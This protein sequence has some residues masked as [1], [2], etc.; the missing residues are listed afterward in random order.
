MEQKYQSDREED[1]EIVADKKITIC[2]VG[3][4]MISDSP[5]Y[6]SI[7]VGTRY[8]LLRNRL[9]EWCREQFKGADCVI[10]NMETVVHV[11][12]NRSLAQSQM[13][14]PESVVGDL[15]EMGFDILNIANNH[16][17]QHGTKGFEK[18]V[19]A[20]RSQGIVPIGLKG[21]EPYIFEIG[22]TKLALLS[23]CIHLE[24]YQPDH[25]LYEDDI[26]RILE[27]VKCLRT[28]DKGI[29]I[30]VSVHWGDEFA[31][32][33][34]NAQ[35]A[36]AHKLVDLG[37]DVILGHHAHIY[38]GVEMYKGALI[39]YCQG[40]FVSDMVPEACRQTGI[41]KI[42][43]DSDSIAY[44]VV[45]CYI[46]D[47]YLPVVCDGEWMNSR[48]EQ[49]LQA[50]QGNCSDEQYWKD[51]SHNHHIGHN[52]F[53]LFFKKNIFKYRR[54]VTARMILDF[55]RRKAKRVTGQSTDGQVSSMDPHIYEVLR[56][57]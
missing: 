52:E 20:C 29:R 56:M 44:S 45:S 17:L 9:V 23:M 27:E 51:V 22:G 36:L 10:G 30:I 8:P 21:Q 14:C 48:N 39:A 54:T 19:E 15:R 35:I 26:K 40:N 47:S 55:L 57:F 38:Q 6:A 46:D 25:I 50:L 37:A 18:T 12:K 31:M 5:L 32:Y 33:P 1:R 7:G 11:P 49:L 42:E 43:I 53:K 24:W 16:C 41:L 13:A 28:E 34:S 2:S 4:I 3:D